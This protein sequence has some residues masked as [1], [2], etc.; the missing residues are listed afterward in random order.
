MSSSANKGMLRVALYI[1]AH[2]QC[3]KVTADSSLLLDVAVCWYTS[4]RNRSPA[5][6]RRDPSRP[7]RRRKNEGGGEEGVRF[8]GG[9]MAEGASVDQPTELELSNGDFDTLCTLAKEGKVD[10]ISMLVDRALELCSGTRVVGRR[11]FCR[12]PRHQKPAPLV[13]AAQYRKKKVVQYFCERYRGRL[14]VNQAATIV[15]L[16]TKKKVHCATALWAASTGGH[17]E[18]VVYLYSRAGSRRQ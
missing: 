12:D 5:R 17:L 2:A 13:V 7:V 14:D 15:S 6:R 16:T 3:L 1:Q 8:C 9:I 11:T 10:K 18:V 4:L